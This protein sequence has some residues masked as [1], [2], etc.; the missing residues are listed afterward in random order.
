MI[1]SSNENATNTEDSEFNYVQTVRKFESSF[2]RVPFEQFRRAFRQEM[3]IAEKDLPTL[4]ALFKKHFTGANAN[5]PDEKVI[6]ALQERIKGLRDKLREAQ[7]ESLKFRERFLKRLKWVENMTSRGNYRIWSR[8]RLIRLIG[9]FLIK[10]D[11][12]NENNFN[13]GIE[14]IEEMGINRP[15]LELLEDFDLELLNVRKEIVKS[16]MERKELDLVLEWCSEHRGNLKRLGS[17]LEFRLRQQEFIELIR[18]GDIKSALKLSQKHFVTWLETNYRE[19]RETLALIC[20]FPFLQRGTRWK[21]GLMKK[22]EDMVGAERWERLRESFER[23]FVEVY[24]VDEG[25]QLIK[26]VK[27]GLSVL[28]TRQCLQEKAEKKCECLDKAGECPVCNGPLGELSKNLPYGH[29]ELT[30]L[31]CRITGKMMSEN[32]PP[33]ALP[34][35]QVFSLSGLKSTIIDKKNNSI[36]KCPVSGESFELSEARKCF[37][38]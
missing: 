16:L 31:R 12:S 21:N 25:I 7:G 10:T 2:I 29:Y 18:N 28:K 35:G 9:D 6:K 33:M 15:E 20:W 32:D 27:T 38:L 5:G 34:N 14:I 37:F 1:S 19:I 8:S 11:D 23:V 22:Y 30:R 3:K 36:V 26:T 13:L 17:D 4:V 24:R